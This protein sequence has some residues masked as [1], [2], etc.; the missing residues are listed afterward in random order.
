MNVV[1]VHQTVHSARAP[2]IGAAP[3]ITASLAVCQQLM[4]PRSPSWWPAPG[5]RVP[6]ALAFADVDA[7][8]AAIDCGP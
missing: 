2:D 8:I 7:A 5:L 3:Q 1:P 6:V 4:L